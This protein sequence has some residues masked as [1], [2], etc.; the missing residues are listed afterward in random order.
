VA[1]NGLPRK[2]APVPIVKEA[3]WGGPRSS[4]DIVNNNNKK[5]HLPLTGFETR[6]V[7][8]TV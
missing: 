8:R 7:H 4:L 1:P 5:K 6:I 2:L 3:R